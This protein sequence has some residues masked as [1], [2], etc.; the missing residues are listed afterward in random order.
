MADET[1]AACLLKKGAQYPRRL[2]LLGPP[3]EVF[4]GF[5]QGAFALYFGDEPYFHFDLDGRWQ[6]AFLAGVHYVKALDTSIDAI[7]RPREGANLVLRRR[8]LPFA[9]A[10]D[11]DAR[12]RSLALD[13]NDGLA[14]GLYSPIHPP[15]DVSPIPIDELRAFLDRV[16]TW[17]ASAWFAQRQLYF[18][19]Y[20][21]QMFVPPEGPN[22]AVIQDL[23]SR[24]R[25]HTFDGIRLEPWRFREHPDPVLEARRVA[26][27]LGRRVAQYKRI[28]LVGDD[29]FGDGGG[30]VTAWIRA[31]SDVFP[32]TPEATRRWEAE[33]PDA[34]ARIEAFS[35]LCDDF[36]SPPPDLAT[37]DELRA[38]RLRRVH[39]GV[40]SG[41]PAVRAQFGKSWPDERL[42]AYVAALK[43]VGLAASVLVLVGAGGLEHDQAHVEQTV[44]LVESLDLGQD[45]FVYLLDAAW[46]SG[47]RHVA[48][49]RQQL[50][51]ALDPLRKARKVKVLT[52]TIEKQ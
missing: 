16:T 31:A 29:L 2:G 18:E 39:L 34:P 33:H 4:A 5:R 14:R 36:S 20:S 38:L 45:D 32:V 24:A 15:D 9:E 23:R 1:E 22:T 43:R 7:E 47:P 27:L 26:A 19:A 21:P 25:G 35:A 30:L 49:Q 3:G 8:T 13:L 10:G 12:F 37:W 44:R 11:L 28:A 46:V 17:D 42:R 51:A 6:R 41:C 52:Y 48:R 40:E 50:R